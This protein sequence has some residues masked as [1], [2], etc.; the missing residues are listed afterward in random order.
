MDK[1]ILLCIFSK[2]FKKNEAC[3]WPTIWCH[4]EYYVYTWE[5]CT[6]C[7]YGVENSMD[8]IGIAYGFTGF[9]SSISFISVIL[10]RLVTLAAN[11][12]TSF[13][14]S[15]KTSLLATNWVFIWEC[16]HF[17]FIFEAVLQNVKFLV[18]GSLPLPP[19]LQTRC[20]SA[21]WPPM[22]W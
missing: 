4:E 12:I 19:A 17:V 11:L 22:F 1:K 6:F 20:S 7:C 15:C 14:T 10:Y 18:T 2:L 8:A 5:E 13:S 9:E 21:F 3:L 16:L